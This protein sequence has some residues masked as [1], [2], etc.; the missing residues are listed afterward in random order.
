[1]NKTKKRNGFLDFLKLIFAIIIVIGHGDKIYG[2]LPPN[3]IMPLAS[4]GVD[5][6]FVVS[7]A[8]L[9]RS[10]EKQKKSKDLGKDTI[11]FMKHKIKGLLPNYYIA[12]IL[13]FIFLS[14]GKSFKS[15]IFSFFYAIPELLFLD[16]TGTATQVFNGNTWYI[17]AMLL[18][19]LILYP[20]IR[21]NKDFF[22]KYIAPMITIFGLGYM[23][24]NYHTLLVIKEWNGFIYLGLIRGIVDISIGCIVF[25]L[26]QLLKKNSLTKTGKTLITILEF[27]LYISIIIMLFSYSFIYTCFVLLFILIIPMCITL[28]DISYSK[29]IFN[30]KIFNWMGKYSYSLYLGHC[31]A[32]KGLI[33]DLIFTGKSYL[34]TMIIYFVVALLCGLAIMY[35]SKLYSYIWDRNKN[36]IKK[37]LVAS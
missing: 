14:V 8:M 6:F 10:I 12:W 23:V 32:Y 22:I 11:Q 33:G 25:E 35:I 28:S 19:I 34:N 20:L 9:L 3:K 30:H 27:I 2:T 4:F 15:I 16:M 7:G 5:F 21:K 37:M 26:S 1:M 29:D 17:S 24:Y 18:S 13:I 36:K 31:I